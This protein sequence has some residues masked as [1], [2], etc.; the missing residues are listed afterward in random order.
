MITCSFIVCRRFIFP[1][2]RKFISQPF[3][4]CTQSS[5]THKP[6]TAVQFLSPTDEKVIKYVQTCDLKLNDV[7][8]G[9]LTVDQQ[10]KEQWE[11]SVYEIYLL[12]LE[13]LA[14]FTN[15]EYASAAITCNDQRTSWNVC[16]RWLKSEFYNLIIFSFV[17]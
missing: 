13:F 12:I 9:K 5:P 7:L 8:A 3:V 11:A 16:K 10:Q 14:V 17:F 6:T 1:F 2:R 15:G 4:R